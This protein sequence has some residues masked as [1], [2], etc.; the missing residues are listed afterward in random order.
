MKEQKEIMKMKNDIIAIIGPS[1]SG[2]IDLAKQLVKKSKKFEKLISY[3]TDDLMTGS[4]EAD[5]AF[6]GDL[7]S[8]ISG[9][10]KM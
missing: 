6:F 1:G 9:V 8:F 5:E 4:P 3:T 10:L 7:D 2:K